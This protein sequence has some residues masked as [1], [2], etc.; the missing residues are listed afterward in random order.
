MI[1]RF[2]AIDPVGVLAGMPGS[3]NR[4]AYT[5]NNPYRYKDPD[6]RWI[7]DA[8]IGAPSLALGAASFV[9][10]V[11]DGNWGSAALDAGGVV[12]DGIAMA[13]PGVPGGAGLAIKAGRSVKGAEVAKSAGKS[14][15]INPGDVANKTPAQIDALAKEK[16][17]IPKGPS[18]QTGKGAY[19]DP[20]TGS[21]RVLCHTNCASPHAHVNNS[22]GQRLD[23]NGNVVPPESP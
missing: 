13:V 4:Y 20:A 3:F 22:Q 18:P 19:V 21:Q 12:A 14:P 1:G 10:N 6:G 16:G 17:L 23:V 5:L 7:E 15:H 2:L 9:N 8:V 11:R